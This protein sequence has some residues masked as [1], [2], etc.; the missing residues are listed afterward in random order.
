[1]DLGALRGR[2]LAANLAAHG[3]AATVTRP[4]PENTP[5]ATTGIWVRPL[6]E[7]REPF[8]V[9]RRRREP[10]QVLSLPRADVATMP[11]GTFIVAPEFTGGPPITWR[12]DGLEQAESDHWRVVVV[13]ARTA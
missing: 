4:A 1:M 13:P 9:N 2:V 5:I 12:W 8:G 7:E 11:E 3:V 6:H 10:R